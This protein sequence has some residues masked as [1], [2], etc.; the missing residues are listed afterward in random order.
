MT[1]TNTLKFATAATLACAGS[2]FAANNPVVL[3]TSYGVMHVSSA[4]ITN[5]GYGGITFGAKPGSASIYSNPWM[6]QFG[7]AMTT[8]AGNTTITSMDF[9]GSGWMLKSASLQIT[10]SDI[11]VDLSGKTI[12]ATVTDGLGS[13]R[14]ALFNVASVTMPATIPPGLIFGETAEIDAAMSGLTLTT[15]A[16]TR[17]GS[18]ANALN[19]VGFLQSIDFGTFNINANVTAVPEPSTYAMAGLGLLAIGAIARRRKPA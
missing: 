7:T 5:L 14:L 15:A 11:S 2:A 12:Y 8:D 19:L 6:T 16:A 9:G 13:D 18:V 3:D 4:A 17:I 1:F 10:Y